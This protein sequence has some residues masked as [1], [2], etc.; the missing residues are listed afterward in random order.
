MKISQEWL[1]DYFVDTLPAPAKLAEL[2]T[3]HLCE[4]EEVE[5]KNGDTIFDLKILPD[6]AH[7]L[8]SNLGV[9]REVSVLTGIALKPETGILPKHNIISEDLTGIKID[10]KEDRLC[11]RYIAQ[12]LTGVRV[13]ASPDWLKQRL[14]SLGQKSIN[15]IVDVGNFVMFDVGQ[16]IHVFD[17]D[18]VKGE[19]IVRLAKSEEKITLLTGHEVT[20]KE[21]DL[22]IADTEGPLAIA[23][24]KGG[25]RAEVTAS[26][27][28]LIIE[29]ANFE[30]TNIRKTSTRLNLRNDSSKR[31]ENEITPA[32]ASL[33]MEKIVKLITELEPQTVVGSKNEV[34][35]NPVSPWEVTVVPDKVASL[36]GVTCSGEEIA[37]I[38]TKMGCVVKNSGASLNIVPPL[39]RL[40]L[41]IPEDMADEVGRV[42][43]YD[44]LPAKLP[45]ELP[46]KLLPDKAF[47]YSEMVKNVLVGR[48]YS[49][50]L[51]YALVAKGFYQVIYPLAS[52]KSALRDTL[53]GKLE[54]ALVVNARRADLLSLPT[55]KIFEVGKVFRSD[56]ERMMLGIGVLPVKKTKG[57]TAEA[58]LKEDL[59]AIE[60]V[61]GISLKAKVVNGDFG[62]VCEV[63][64]DELVSNLAPQ[65]N[66][67]DLDFKPL[68]S[69]KKYQKF[70]L[71]PYIVRDVAVFV[72]EEV[73]EEVV[74]ELIKSKATGLCIKSELFDV[75]TK[76]FGDG[77][78]KSLAFRLIFQ[79][80]EK[81]L[82]DKEVNEI[83]DLIYQEMKL[84]AD[85]QIR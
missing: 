77:K 81:T 75:F 34:Y 3:V 23:G 38:L 26:T 72:P 15:N 58:I 43:G 63:D 79:S 29:A 67:T 44:K 56:G 40:D 83:M 59:L 49:E 21:T 37:S 7:Y 60:D 57:V 30:P 8:L 41:V 80:F 6:R 82:E 13:E 46:A 76:D 47:F 14:E 5:E 18:K 84:K 4:V 42:L 24:V 9:A 54:E 1:Q 73:S 35:P 78:K 28:N 68:P 74:H 62:S 22:V 65:R 2:F 70:S 27:T 69:D 50:T 53:L 39:D 48:G 36:V 71:Y 52:D 32:L 55:I 51:L 12:T 61:L 16:P 20:L 17:A 19:I 85:W 25:K 45:A 10:I 33:G 64:F 66:L 11:R 31:F